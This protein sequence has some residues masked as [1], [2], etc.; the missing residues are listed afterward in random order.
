[1]KG[2]TKK[3][4][5]LRLAVVFIVLPLFFYMTGSF[6]RRT[7]IKEAISILTILAFCS[8]LAQF[9]LNRTSFASFRGYKKS[10][11]ITI[12]KILGYL[13]L[14]ILL[15]HPFLIVLPRNFEAGVDSAEA[16]ITIIT[17]FNSTGIILGITAWCLMLLLGVSSLLRNKLPFTYLNWRL[18]HG[19]LA[20]F[21]ICLASWHAIVLGRHSTPMMS[22]YVIMSG[23]SGSLI[24]FRTYIFRS[25]S[26]RRQ[27]NDRS[28][29]RS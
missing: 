5:I 26:N 18:L 13:F 23:V 4:G 21:F 6:P 12:H 2:Q 10:S 27:V 1:M 11:V 22:A 15:I 20:V 19:I 29:R 25:Y 17:A 28:A 7:F 3:R 9:F 24:L 14:P 8:M 16:F